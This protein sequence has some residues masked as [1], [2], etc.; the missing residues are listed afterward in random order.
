[1]T[2]LPTEIV[3]F[4][5]EVD[6]AVHTNDLEAAADALTWLRQ[7]LSF[8]GVS[9]YVH[10]ADSLPSGAPLLSTTERLRASIAS[11]QR[12]R[13][14]RR[15]ELP[16]PLLDGGGA[17][18]PTSDHELAADQLFERKKHRIALGTGTTDILT[19]RGEGTGLGERLPERTDL[20]LPPKE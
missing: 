11:A 18:S 4:I 16:D 20:P 13:S 9:Y 10:P 8:S 5:L 3:A 2:R 7:H 17:S 12:S 19:I 1:M 6:S 14:E 15:G